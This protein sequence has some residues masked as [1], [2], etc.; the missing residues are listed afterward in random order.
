MSR[1]VVHEGVAVVEA[2]LGARLR[3]VVG[4]IDAATL[5]AQSVVPR[6]DTRRKTGYQRDIT[7]ARVNRL[8]RDL[9]D[10]RVDLPTAV[11]LNLRDFDETRHLSRNAQELR[12]L[13]AGAELYVVDG[14]HRVGA[15][16]KLLDEPAIKKPNRPGSPR[17]R[18]SR[19]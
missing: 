14:Q 2:R 12:F 16:Q 3:T 17:C 5:T 6:R 8:A 19:C 7:A 11:L 18:S 4:F 13:T 10:G 9:R 15:L 1:A